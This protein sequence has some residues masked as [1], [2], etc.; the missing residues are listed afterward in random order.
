MIQPV[1]VIKPFN[2]VAAITLIILTAIIGYSLGFI[3]AG[4]LG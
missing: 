4:I 3:G 2:P 1:Y